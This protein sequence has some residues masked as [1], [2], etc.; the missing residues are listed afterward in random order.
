MGTDNRARNIV[1]ASLLGTLVFM[2]ALGGF[3]WW[4]LGSEEDAVRD[5]SN[6]LITASSRRTRARRPMTRRTT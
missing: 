1:I 4:Y 3:L 6:E 5:A 2:A